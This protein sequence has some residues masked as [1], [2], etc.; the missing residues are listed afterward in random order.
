MTFTLGPIPTTPAEVIDALGLSFD[1]ERVGT[2]ETGGSEYRV[3]I[4][5]AET[6]VTMTTRYCQSRHDSDRG[7]DPD[8]AVVIGCLL[9]D[10]TYGDSTPDD[11][12]R[13]MGYGDKPP[14][15]WIDLAAA[16]AKVRS[17]LDRLCGSAELAEA[18]AEAVEW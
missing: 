18:I 10:Y 4:E 3:T 6:G 8:P 17:G 9:A 12:W 7:A 2:W 5:G 15:H 16:L 14:S 13:D 11:L 1:F